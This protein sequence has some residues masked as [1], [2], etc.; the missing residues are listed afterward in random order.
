MGVF[1]NIGLLG[2]ILILTGVISS[3]SIIGGG[4]H[5]FKHF[6]DYK[7]GN[8]NYGILVGVVSLALLLINIAL[9]ALTCVKKS[10]LVFPS[11]CIIGSAVYNG[12]LYDNLDSQCTIYYE[13]ENKKLWNFY[14]YYML[15][16]IVIILLI[17]TGFMWNCCKKKIV[18]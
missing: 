5:I 2:G 12:Y 8:L 18:M 3:G 14:V 7:C 17:V 13:T 9:Y 10:S 6:N 11:L 16:L 4:V 15:A 1:S